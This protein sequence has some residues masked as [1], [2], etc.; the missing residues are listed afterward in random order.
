MVRE[1]RARARALP[2]KENKAKQNKTALTLETVA[3]KFPTI[4]SPKISLRSFFRNVFSDC[5]NH[6][7]ILPCELLVYLMLCS[8]HHDILHAMKR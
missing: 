2:S 4:K 8:E 6:G 5:V 7:T 1:E 3:D